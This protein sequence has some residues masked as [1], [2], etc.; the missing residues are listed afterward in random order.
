MTSSVYMLISARPTRFLLA[1]ACLLCTGWIAVTPAFAQDDVVDEIVA[2][3][4]NEIILRSDVD[5][6]VYGY[7]QQGQTAYSP[8]LWREAM[9]QLIDQNVL[10]ILAKRDTTIEVT[11]DQVDQALDQRIEQLTAQVGTQAQLEEIYG[12]SVVQIRA[13]LREEFRDRLLAE[14]YQNRKLQ[15]IKV[16]PSEVREW[17]NEIPQDSLPMVPAVIRAAHVVRYPEPSPEA[18]A[19]ALEIITTIRDSIVTSDATI[20][21]MAQLFSDDVASAQNGGRLQDFKL[22]DLVPEFAAVASRSPIGEI[23]QVFETPFGYHILR[24]NSRRGDIV[25]FNH[26]LIQ[27]DRTKFDATGTITFLSTLRDSVLNHNVPFATIARRHSEEEISAQRGGRIVDPRTMERDL[28]LDA[29]GPSW[30]STI[31]TLEVD[32]ISRPAEVELLDGEQAF[33]IVK[34]T[35]RVPAHRM[36][37]ETD[38]ERIEQ[39]VLQEK[40]SLVMREWLD[41]LRQDV[42]IEIRGKAEAL[43]VA[44]N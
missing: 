32:E 7:M 22:D 42:Y 6:L 34:L 38:Y 29:L 33:H 40:R 15:Q 20:E 44:Q 4:G 23:S 18:R 2:I 10:T 39:Y 26:I 11:D 41:Q 24:V 5:G 1:L 3:V 28:V 36:N 16:T 25:D 14:Q 9:N 31:D 27:I 35:S 12:K 21:E 19:D 43:S 8:E 17:F 37:I 13:D 30:R